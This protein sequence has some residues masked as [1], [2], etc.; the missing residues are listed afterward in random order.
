MID[1]MQDKGEAYQTDTRKVSD[2]EIS[3]LIEEIPG[4]SIQVGDG[5]MQVEKRF[6]FPDFARALAFTNKVG[7]LA[8]LEG[9]HPK[10]TIQWGRVVVTWASHSGKGLH[11]NHLVMAAK[12]ER[13]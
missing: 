11:R 13:L 3:T 8:E 10:L 5:I 1:V 12:T 4:W 9:H 2:E 7:E 6:E